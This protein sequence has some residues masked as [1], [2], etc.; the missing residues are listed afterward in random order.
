MSG[1]NPEASLLGKVSWGLGGQGGI[2][3]HPVRILSNGLGQTWAGLWGCRVKTH[4][5]LL[6]CKGPRLPGPQHVLVT[7]PHCPHHS[8]AQC[9][10]LL[11]TGRQDERGKLSLGTRLSVL[12]APSSSI[13]PQP[14][15]ALSSL[16]DL[17]AP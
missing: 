2:S 16:A 6:G 10:S 7:T 15:C 9:L 5:R 11:P 8:L 12:S 1:L 13:V 4:V 17:M 3:F 14:R